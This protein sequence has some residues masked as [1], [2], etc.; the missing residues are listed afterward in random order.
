MKVIYEKKELV[1]IIKSEIS[2]AEEKYDV[3]V[4]WHAGVDTDDFLVLGSE[5]L[6]VY[7]EIDDYDSEK[8]C[9]ISIELAR[10]LKKDKT[11]LFGDI[12][13]NDNNRY[14]YYFNMK[15]LLSTE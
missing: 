6:D 8:V 1:E 3:D 2:Q 7:V 15:K 14:L 12:S 9:E 13:W 10:E 5:T 4:V 11:L